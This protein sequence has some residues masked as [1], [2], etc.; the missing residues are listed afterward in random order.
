M[1]TRKT[2]KLKFPEREE[3][4][5]Y[6]GDDM[7]LPE[8][9]T[10]FGTRNQCLKKGVGIGMVIP[11]KRRIHMVN[12]PQ[13]K[14][15]ST[16]YCG[17]GELPAN[18]TGYDTRNGCLKRGV[19]IGIRSPEDKRKALQAKPARP[20]NRI[21]L[22]TLAERFKVNTTGMSRDNIIDILSRRIREL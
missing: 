10:D 18:Y 13:T 6:C 2:R 20:L 22:Q 5:L 4:L 1:P 14:P 21:E 8:F 12:K 16:L 19:G 7:L 15:K 3:K 17:D 9:Y 11:D